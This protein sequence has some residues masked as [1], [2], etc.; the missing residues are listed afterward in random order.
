MEDAAFTLH[1][2]N[3]T[4]SDFT[5]FLSDGFWLE[6]T[7][8][9]TTATDQAGSNYFSPH[10]LLL[11]TTTNQMDPPTTQLPPPRRLWI[12]PNTLTNP[13]PTIPVNTRL[14]QAIEYLKNYTT[15][16]DVLIQIW[17]PVNRGGK[18]VLITNN[19]PYFLNPNSHSLLEYRNV[20]QTYQFAAEKDSKELVGLPGRVFL[21]KQPEWTPDVRFF[22]REEYPRVRYAHQ[23]NV[24]GSIAIPV[25]E[26]GSGT[27][28]GVVEIVTTIQ[29]TPEL[30][31][32]CK[33]LEFAL[34]L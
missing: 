22:K 20:S 34:Q 10:P 4:T 27:C 30:E 16:K 21:K 28:L 1:D 6:T 33:A 24:S 29:K 17:V 25:F 13:N 26:S 19:Q 2:N 31:D 12:G 14:V 18:H 15:H 3:N 9:T 7:T 23:H 5:E 32:V 11:D 8:T